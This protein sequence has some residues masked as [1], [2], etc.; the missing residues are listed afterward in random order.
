MNIA[1]YCPIEFK[2]LPM[3]TPLPSFHTMSTPELHIGL[4]EAKNKG[5]MIDLMREYISCHGGW[6]NAPSE[7]FDKLNQMGQK[8]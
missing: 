1:M 8:N 6:S 3:S 5:E 7:V 2:E 4:M